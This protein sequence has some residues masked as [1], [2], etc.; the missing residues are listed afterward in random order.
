MGSPP[1]GEIGL[2]CDDEESSRKATVS[3]LNHVEG[4]LYHAGHRKRQQIWRLCLRAWQCRRGFVP[5]PARQLTFE[6]NSALAPQKTKV[7]ANK[8][9]KPPKMLSN[10]WGVSN[11]RDESA[12]PHMQI[13]LK[14]VFSRATNFTASLLEWSPRKKQ[15]I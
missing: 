9:L 14:R 2:Q 13:R 3:S 11:A 8:R 4:E 15:V 1:A 6:T 12:H 10:R 7:S 5:A